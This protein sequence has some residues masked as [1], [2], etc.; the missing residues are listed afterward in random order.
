MEEILIIEDDADLREILKFSLERAGYTTLEAG[1]AEHGMDMVSDKTRL[2]LLDV[3]LPGISGYEMA[4]SLREKGCRTP[5]IFLTARSSEEDL[6]S[7]F[8]S[9]GDD[10]MSKPFSTAELLARIGAVL[11]RSSADRSGAV[12]CGPLVIDLETEKVLLDGTEIRL[13]RKE[14]EI[15]AFLIQNQGKLFTRSQI[16]KALWLDAPFVIDRTVDVHIAHIRSKLD[17]HKGLLVSR[18]GFGYGLKYE[19]E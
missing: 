10:Y 14:Y 17:V 7:G 18:V 11:K 12:S 8:A 19:E 4:K 5:I 13:S 1:S 15:L 9:G 3:M 16:I 2:I 6:L